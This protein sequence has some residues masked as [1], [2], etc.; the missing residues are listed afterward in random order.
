MQSSASVCS[1]QCLCTVTSV[2]VQSPVSVYSHQCL[3]AV[4]SV[5]V[6]SPA[7]VCSHQRL[8]TVTSVRVQ[9]LA[10]VFTFKS[11]TGSDLEEWILAAQMAGEFKT[12]TC[13]ICLSLH[14]G[15]TASI[16]RGMQNKRCNYCAVD[17]GDLFEYSL[18]H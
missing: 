14:S 1:H 16:E 8:C 2:C 7:S 4:T 17:L 5:C 15:Y 11:T 10:S 9:S 6:Q 3:C 13:T 12:V 18:L